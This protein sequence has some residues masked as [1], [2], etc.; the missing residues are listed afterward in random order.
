[1]RH[2][3]ASHDRDAQGGEDLHL[4]AASRPPG[5]LALEVALGLARDLDALLAR[6]LPEAV[7]AGCPGGRAPFG[8]RVLGQLDVRQ[9]AY[10]QDLVAVRRDLRLT[11]EPR[12]G[13]APG[14]PLAEILSHR[15]HHYLPAPQAQ[16]AWTVSTYAASSCGLLPSPLRRSRTT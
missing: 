9:A 8:R 10:H 11:D 2:A 5:D 4:I 16:P 6:L 7:D 14:K 15:L 12:L 1:L 13:Q 3:Q